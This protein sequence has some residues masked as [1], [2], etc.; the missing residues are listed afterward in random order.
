M[1]DPKRGR[2]ASSD[3]EQNDDGFRE[4]N[5]EPRTPSPD[6][7]PYND[8]DLEGHHLELPDRSDTEVV[9][10]ETE[11]QLLKPNGKEGEKLSRAEYLQE[12]E[13]YAD[14]GLQNTP[15][16]P[17]TTLYYTSDNY[18]VTVYLGVRI[19]NSHAPRTRPADKDVN[20]QSNGCT[21]DDLEKAKADDLQIYHDGIPCFFS[22]KHAEYTQAFEAGKTFNE[23]IG[24]FIGRAFLYKVQTDDIHFDVHDDLTVDIVDGH[25]HGGEFKVPQLNARLRFRSGNVFL[26]FTPF[27]AHRVSP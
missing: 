19:I 3:D 15:D 21:E 2:S 1:S 12:L 25:F 20:D 13:A 7:S 10:S 16:I 11:R 5:V 14:T 18:L 27:L 24:P 26:G 17:F 23:D 22:D 9:E 6:G 4:A 8:D